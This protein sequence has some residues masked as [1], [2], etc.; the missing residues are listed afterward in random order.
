MYIFSENS[1]EMK[2]KKG[3]R[4]ITVKI[5]GKNLTPYTALTGRQAQQRKVCY[6]EKVSFLGGH[7]DASLASFAYERPSPSWEAS[8]QMLSHI[9]IHPGHTHTN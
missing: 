3:L 2:C 5:G 1:N 7:G 8:T 6:I 4:K 9:E